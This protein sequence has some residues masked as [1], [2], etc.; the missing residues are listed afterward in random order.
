MLVTEIK[1]V[2]VLLVT[3]I[4]QVTVLLVMADSKTISLFPGD[5]DK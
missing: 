5:S 1:Q 2:T 4:K 3:E